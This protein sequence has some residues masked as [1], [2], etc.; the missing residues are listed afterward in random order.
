[1]RH[2]YWIILD[3]L[4]LAPTEI[5]E[6]LNRVLDDNRSVFITETQE[7]VKAHPHF[8]LFATQNPPGLYAGRKML[9]RALRNRFIELHF[10]T[11]PRNELE[12]ILEKKCL[13][14]PSRAHR[15]VE[16]MHRLQ[17]A[18]CSSNLFQGKD[19]FITLRDLFRWAERYRLATCDKVSN[20]SDDT[21][22][23]MTKESMQFFDWD[24]YLADQGYLLLAGRVRNEAEVQVVADVIETVFKRKVTESRLFDLN[25]N[26]S[27]AVREF[28]QPILGKNV[29][30]SQSGFE[31]IVWTRD[32]RRL[33]VLI[34]NALK[35]EEPVLLVGE[36]GCG[37]TTVCQMIAAMHNQRLHC[38]NCHQC[39]E[40]S[41]FLGGLRPIRHSSVDEKKS[42][43]DCHLFE[44]VNGPLV[45]AMLNGDVF[46]LDE[47]S[48]A[49]DAVLERL[50]SLLE[51]ERQLHLAECTE[52]LLDGSSLDST[53]LT[54][55]S[56]FRF[57]ATMNPGG[58]YGKKE[59]S[60]ALRNR[61]TEIWCPSPIFTP[62]R[63]STTTAPDNPNH[64]SNSLSDCI[65]IVL[66]NLK[67]KIPAYFGNENKLAKPFSEKMVD[68]VH[69]FAVT[70]A[71]CK[72]NGFVSLCHRSPP[73]IRDLI[74]WI[75]FIRVVTSNGHVSNSI[76]KTMDLFTACIHG[77]CLI[78]LDALDETTVEKSDEQRNNDND[79]DFHSMT[80]HYLIEQL[81]SIDNALIQS[82][83]PLSTTNSDV[84]YAEFCTK[85]NEQF[86]LIKS[87]EL[88]GCEP[89]FISTGPYLLDNDETAD[90]SFIFDAPTPA[91]NLKRLLRAMQL[92]GRALLL[93]GSPGVGKTTLVLA[94][95]KAS[96]HKVIRINLSE[97]TEASDL[98][99]CDLPVEGAEAGVFAWKSG[100]FLQGLCEGHWIILDEMNLASQSV[101]ECLNACLDHRGEVFIPEL[102]T[103]FKINS[104]TTR[105][106]ACQN[107]LREGGGRKGLP[108]SFLN[109]FTQV[110]MKS[111]TISDQE[112]ILVQLYPGIPKSCIHLIVAFNQEVNK[113]INIEREFGSQGGPWEFNLRDL[114]RW[115]DLLMKGKIVT[116]WN[117]CCSKLDMPE[118]FYYE[119][120]GDIRLIFNESI[121][122]G[123]AHLKHLKSAKDYS[124]Y[125]E[126]NHLLLLDRQRGV[127]ESF[128]KV[129][130]MGWMVMLIGPPGCGKR[131][132]AHI[133]SI[134]L[135][136]NILSMCLSPTSDTIELLG[137]LEQRE[138]GGLFEWVDSPL[139][140]GIVNGNWVLIENAQLCSPSTLDRLNSL[141][142]PNGELLLSERG[143][144]A[145][146]KL[147]TLKAHP[148]FRLILTIDEVG[149]GIGGCAGSTGISR[150]MRNRGLEITFTEPIS[151]PH[152]DLLRL[153]TSINV[154]KLI[155][156]GLVEFSVLFLEACENTNH[157]F[158]HHPTFLTEIQASVSSS[159]SSTTFQS[160]A[161][162][163][164][165]KPP[166]GAL[167]SAGQY[168]KQLLTNQSQLDSDVS[169]GSE[170]EKIK[171]TRNKKR[172][173]N[174]QK[175]KKTEKKQ[176]LVDLD[177]KYDISVEVDF[178]RILK[179][180]LHVA[181]CQRQMNAKSVD[182]VQHLITYYVENMFT[183]KASNN[184]GLMIHLPTNYFHHSVKELIENRL[185]NSYRQFHAS[186][187]NLTLSEYSRPINPAL[188]LLAK[189]I[190]LEQANLTDVCGNKDDQLMNLLTQS[191]MEQ[192]IVQPDW[193]DWPD[194]RWIPGWKHLIGELDRESNQLMYTWNK[195]LYS[196]LLNDLFH[197]TN[198]FINT[199]SFDSQSSAC[200]KSSAD[201][202][203]IPLLQVIK[204]SSGNNLPVM[205]L[206]NYPGL[207]DLCKQ[208]INYLNLLWTQF[209]SFCDAQPTD[210]S[211]L[212]EVV[213]KAWSWIHLFGS[214]PLGDSFDWP[215]RCAF[216]NKRV[217]LTV[218]D[219]FESRLPQL[220]MIL[221]Y[222][223]KSTPSTIDDESQS[224]VSVLSFNWIQ[225]GQFLNEF[226]LRFNSELTLEKDVSDESN[227]E[228]DMMNEEN[229]DVGSN[230]FTT[231]GTNNFSDDATGND[232]LN[233]Y[234][235]W[236]WTMILVSKFIESYLFINVQCH[237]DFYRSMKKSLR[238]YFRCVLMTLNRPNLLAY[239]VMAQSMLKG[240]SY[241]QIHVVKQLT[242]EFTMTSSESSSSSLLLSSLFQRLD[243]SLPNQILNFRSVN[244]PDV[245]GEWR[246][247]SHALIH[248]T[249][250]M[251][252]DY[253]AYAYCGR[254]TV[255]GWRNRQRAVQKANHLLFLSPSKCEELNDI[256]KEEFSQSRD[257]NSLVQH[258]F[259]IL[260]GIYKSISSVY[261]ST[262]NEHNDAMYSVAVCDNLVDLVT[263][264]HSCLKPLI[265]IIKSDLTNRTSSNW[266]RI[267][268]LVELLTNQLN[269]ML[270]PS[271]VQPNIEKAIVHTN[272]S[273]SIC[274]LLIGCLY[275]RCVCPHS[276]LDPYLVIQV[277]EEAVHYEMNSINSELEFRESIQRHAVGLY[278]CLQSLKN[279]PPLSVTEHV[280][281]G[282]LHPWLGVL[283]NRQQYLREKAANLKHQLGSSCKD[284]L[285]IRQNSNFEYVEIRRRITTFLSDFTEDFLLPHLPEMNNNY[286]EMIE[287]NLK[288]HTVNR[289]IEATSN[290]ADWLTDA[291]RFNTFADI[292]TPFLYGLFYVYRGL[293]IVFHEITARSNP[294]NVSISSMMQMLIT[295]LL[296]STKN[297]TNILFPLNQRSSQSMSLALELA[298]PK[299]RRIIQ[300]LVDSA[301]NFTS[302]NMNNIQTLH[303]TQEI[304]FR[305]SSF[306]LDL[307]WLHNAET[308]LSNVS[309]NLNK[310]TGRLLNSML[311]PLAQ[312][313]KQ[314]EA[315]RKRISEARAALF[316]E[317]DRRKQLIRNELQGINSSKSK[318]YQ[319]NQ[320]CHS[321]EL[322][323]QSLND[324]LDWRL[325]FSETGSLK[326]F[327]ELRG[328]LSNSAGLTKEEE[329]QQ[330][331]NKL[332]AVDNWLKKSLN[333]SE[334]YWI[335]DE[336]ELTYFI[337]RLVDLLLLFFSIGRHRKVL[338]KTK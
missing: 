79:V 46:L 208:W 195:Y 85:S 199:S 263:W 2:G 202:C 78:F 13:L 30:V 131:T 197:S 68:F 256:P 215:E 254:L 152:L 83:T 219:Q 98:F 155:A 261:K 297:N 176:P 280:N 222:L 198:Q 32:M 124:T 220:S 286:V 55:H 279:L 221:Q 335:P 313:W 161:C 105:L 31:H 296:P 196:L 47:I 5:L 132:L 284:I 58:D 146:G 16:V 172:K 178:G 18:R 23:D 128:L 97:A 293:R 257:M 168:A 330:T 231:S 65:E 232:F 212:Y 118:M 150:A 181:Y 89:F 307:L 243:W 291:H 100:P 80:I 52:D 138:A 82:I 86:M 28:L 303:K 91:S 324:E 185:P 37:K 205:W 242:Q 159:S 27:P 142:E 49:D 211:Q 248:L 206:D 285:T 217:M 42:T 213:S 283:V 292:I 334:K 112:F 234:C 328:G 177:D 157:F 326:A 75:E 268:C 265:S 4:N 274:W 317:A 250:P 175:K 147:V 121:Q 259:N 193:M 245:L 90:T 156:T 260:H 36:T 63:A 173:L 331:V 183:C 3:E 66:H 294:L 166:I 154:P 103:T 120:H 302:S 171:M 123:F 192:P 320:R 69:W 153:F 227:A 96:G 306:L 170:T 62:I 191:T 304:Q 300:Q 272:F 318:T 214:R 224:E 278:N 71:E 252:S 327:T 61:F 167:I 332:A 110:Y 188:L 164:L 108:R 7:T 308:N 251:L 51:P 289:W 56:K 94:L 236:P 228:D 287:K 101:L 73:T 136:Q 6:A 179:H 107:P 319:Q 127:M 139:V 50:N 70:Q 17:L 77:A 48:L 329:I 273:L 8:R 40:A 57:I 316:L 282:L 115:C 247:I 43:D 229:T 310:L 74:A 275:L 26:T 312:Q 133:A 210:L 158:E 145:N 10:D 290:L 223:H 264:I 244:Q 246:S 11:I 9:S 104:Q 271:S 209:P 113:R 143:L 162:H 321:P 114:T 276:P 325:R 88:F 125:D 311:R 126:Y 253:G 301:N 54:A 315:E 333:S 186:L 187:V 144:D 34:G 122:C 295:S 111:L 84:I 64:L 255:Y 201:L 281:S 130:E 241:K 39:T 67:L 87:N 288:L 20:Q 14:P 233:F 109:R 95:A 235:L 106:F 270:V 165:K 148:N 129:I 21:D 182:F 163:N 35:Y 22:K 1:M 29:V 322:V 323:D 44:W 140:K 93:E 38:V 137:S 267:A 207:V 262:N 238:I 203:N 180:V 76:G 169:N 299:S 189:R 338:W 15:L 12:I 216:H 72:S 184:L 92:P 190:L 336:N 45:V 239:L 218:D 151:Q 337:N 25:E 230:D 194:L 309:D 204:L 19:S 41:D 258:A 99:G 174:D 226:L 60:P 134:I 305:I 24:A 249:W 117:E 102:N 59:L 141:L 33:L 240:S 135:G 119:P 277:E 149:G 200:I 225:F 53:Q 266:Y 298:S 314:I 81:T 269:E 237:E 116:L 160:I